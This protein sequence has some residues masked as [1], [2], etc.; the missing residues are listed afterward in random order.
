MI[1]LFGRDRVPEGRW[2]ALI[3][4]KKD[5]MDRLR[6]QDPDAAARADAPPAPT[7]YRD[8]PSMRLMTPEESQRGTAVEGWVPRDRTPEVRNLTLGR[9]GPMQLMAPNDPRRVYA[10]GIG[11][12]ASAANARRHNQIIQSNRMFAGPMQRRNEMKLW[13]DRKAADQAMYADRADARRSSEAISL[14]QM[15][16]ERDRGST[17]EKYAAD[18]ARAQQEAER[19]R[20]TSLG[21]GSALIPDGKGGYVRSDAPQATEVKWGEMKQFP[22]REGVFFQEGPNGEIKIK[23]LRPQSNA[24]VFNFGPTTED[25]PA[26]ST[27]AVNQP[28]EI[29]RKYLGN[30]KYRYRNLKNGNEWEE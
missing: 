17:A 3:Q 14:N 30:G 29:V 27:P 24:P 9:P 22:G 23:D 2:D 18:A 6:A 20:P 15:Q 26:P 13:L 8:N 25:S 16:G 19:N 28:P 4:S 10:E 5:E 11:D 12:E 7:Y 21:G 1:R